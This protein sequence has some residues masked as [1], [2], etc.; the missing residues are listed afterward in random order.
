MATAAAEPPEGPPATRS[1]IPWVAHRAPV[2][3]R[4]RRAGIELV[5]VGLADEHGAGGPEAANH[6]GVF[7][8]E[9]VFVDRAGGGGAHP[10]GVDAVLDAD[11]NAVQR[12]ADLPGDLFVGERLACASAFS[13][14]TVIQALIFG[15][16][17]S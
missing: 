15:I 12:S 11:G 3:D 7:R 9:A 2:A 14:I 4:G 5:H 16:P 6:L 8:R 1:R 13:R 17:E 10:G